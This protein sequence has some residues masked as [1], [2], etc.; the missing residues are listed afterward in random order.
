MEAADTDFSNVWD[1]G[2]GGGGASL[3]W[4][5]ARGGGGGGEDRDGWEVFATKP[6]TLREHLLDQASMTFSDPVEQ[7]IAAAVIDQLDEA[8]YFI[9]DFEELAGLTGVDTNTVSWVHSRILQFD[10][11]GIAARS[12]SECLRLQLA[13]RGEASE[14]MQVLLDNLPLVAKRDFKQLCRLCDVDLAELSQIV[15]KLRGCAPRPASMFDYPPAVTVIPDV[16]VRRGADRGWIVELNPDALPHVLANREYY[17][18]VKEHS[19]SQA[20]IDFVVRQ[21]HSANWLIK[22]LEQRANTILKVASCIVQTQD[23]FLEHGVTGLRPL[24]LRDVAT[25]VGVHESTVSRVT[26]GKYIATQRGVFELKYFFTAAA[27]SADGSDG[28]SVEVVRH[29][30]R[31]L[32]ENETAKDVLSDENLVQLLRRDGMEIARRTVAKYRESMNIPSSAQRR[33][34]LKLEAG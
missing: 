18:L 12:L 20:E 13:E 21:W 15:E 17:A 6:I 25:E 10:P 29:R 32:V 5:D 24:T 31:Q 26:S 33:R 28:Q 30:I 22:A 8:G 14:P 7:Q 27:R 16:M 34:L 4:S 1:D 23:R 11:T 19:R 3:N 2:G 9:G